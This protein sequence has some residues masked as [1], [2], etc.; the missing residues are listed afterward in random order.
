MEKVLE[1]LLVMGG[2]PKEV[3]KNKVSLGPL[4]SRLR[5]SLKIFE[6]IE[7][8]IKEKIQK[9]KGK[10]EEDLGNHVMTFHLWCSSNN[11]IENII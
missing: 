6:R 4:W 11:I 1:P 9:F 7:I 10:Q 3:Y 8:I 2:G 5:I